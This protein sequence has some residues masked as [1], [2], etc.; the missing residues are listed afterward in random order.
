MPISFL[1]FSNCIC[2]DCGHLKDSDE[3]VSIFFVFLDRLDELSN[4]NLRFVWR[5]RLGRQLIM[6]A[7]LVQVP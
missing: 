3:L 1:R 2:V 7:M 6:Y 4:V 5:M